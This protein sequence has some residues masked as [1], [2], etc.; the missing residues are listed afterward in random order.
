VDNDDENGGR[1][2][3]ILT[4]KRRIHPL[5]LC[6]RLLLLLLLG[7]GPPGTVRHK[8]KKRHVVTHNRTNNDNT[9]HERIKTRT[10]LV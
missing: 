6:H 8:N 7:V 2:I 10:I 1:S 9:A 4:R 3:L 5:R